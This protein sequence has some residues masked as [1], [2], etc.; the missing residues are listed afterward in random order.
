MGVNCALAK[1][2][3]DA[4]LGGPGG[5]GA[6]PRCRHAL[7][8]RPDR[9][10]NRQGSSGAGVLDSEG[11]LEQDRLLLAPLCGVAVV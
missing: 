9:P 11:Q 2:E 4:E 3:A 1:T 8:G 5:G 10:V 7:H 6:D